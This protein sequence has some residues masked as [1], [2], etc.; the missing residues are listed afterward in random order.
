M[1]VKVAI[2]VYHFVN[3][4]G[5]LD[6]KKGLHIHYVHQSVRQKRSKVALIKT[7]TLTVSVYESLVHDQSFDFVA[8]FCLCPYP[9]TAL[10]S[11]WLLVRI[12]LVVA[13]DFCPKI[14]GGG[15]DL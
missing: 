2:K 14:F 12:T 9:L 7:M 13:F 15:R 10:T 1:Y 5:L 8:F 4:D 6:G 11:W 3:G